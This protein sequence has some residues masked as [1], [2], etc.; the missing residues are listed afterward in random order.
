[1]TG[2]LSY[3]G[4]RRPLK[5]GSCSPTE[6]GDIVSQ[7]DGSLVLE[8]VL[9]CETGKQHLNVFIF[10]RGKKRIYGDKSYVKHMLSGKGDQGPGVRKQLI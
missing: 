10:Q 3:L 8:I 1:M 9:G 2:G 4:A 6:T 7:G 5:L